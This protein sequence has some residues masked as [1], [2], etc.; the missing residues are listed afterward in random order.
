MATRKKPAIQ[1]RQ[2]HPSGIIDDVI[3]PVV[4]K[5]ARA[6]ADRGVGKVASKLDNVADRAVTQ[7]AKNYSQK[8]KTLKRDLVEAG[9]SVRGPKKPSQNYKKA[10]TSAKKDMY[11]LRAYIV[12]QDIIRKTKKK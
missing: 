6:V 12:N 2:G 1:I 5:A 11:K 10:E 8:G 4:S 7:R 9:V 3:L